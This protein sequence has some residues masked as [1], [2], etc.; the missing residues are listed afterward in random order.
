MGAYINLTNEK[1]VDI[2]NE[3][4]GERESKTL[5]QNKPILVIVAAQPGAG[6][7]AAARLAKLEAK[8]N[9]GYIHVDAD[10]MR[11][12]IPLD[13][14][15][16]PPSEQ[17]QQDAGALAN[18][19]RNLAIEGRRNIIEEGTFRLP[20]AFR[21]TI[22]RMHKLGY[23]VELLAVATS[24]EESQLGIFQR[25]ED[26]CASPTTK[27]PRFVRSEYHNSAMDGFTANIEQDGALFDRARVITRNGQILFDSNSKENAQNSVYEALI[28]GRKM[29]RE[30]IIDIA[31][32]WE[33]VKAQA[34]SRNAPKDY[35]DEI[36]KHAKH[37]NDLLTAKSD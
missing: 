15:V 2:A 27:N 31:N 25:Y 21:N 19:V 3:F 9:G 32:A 22:D 16:N 24:R 4:Y 7:S 6:K 8:Q 20:N 29:P 13:D 34:V 28:A 11:G 18:T 1:V 14:G 33:N 35:L 12:K 5:P 17:T 10:V 26:Q 30:K 36:D 23:R 37:I